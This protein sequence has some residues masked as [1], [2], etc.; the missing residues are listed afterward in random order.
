MYPNGPQSVEDLVASFQNIQITRFV[1]GASITVL[2]YDHLLTFSDEVRFVWRAEGSA[3]RTLFLFLRYSVPACMVIH[4]LTISGLV[5]LSLPDNSCKAWFIFGAYLGTV[6]IAIT[7]FLVLLRLWILWGRNASLMK[8]TGSIFL[9]CQFGAI[10]AVCFLSKELNRVLV[11]DHEL[12]MCILSEKGTLF[13]LWVPGLLFETMIF[14]TATVNGF[15]RRNSMA[16]D[17]SVKVLYRH[18]LAYFVILFSLRLVNT[19]MAIV[20]DPSL[21]FVGVFLVWSMSTGCDNT[22]G[23]QSSSVPSINSNYSPYS[24][25]APYGREPSKRKTYSEFFSFRSKHLS[26]IYIVAFSSPSCINGAGL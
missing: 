4:N 5:H 9:L 14:V 20:A 10:I 8:F 21:I 18:G 25:F 6:T 24:F 3:A 17:A 7:N 22:A 23:A 15:H 26:N 19:V 13:E 11:F 1:T 2:L 12:Q 16:N